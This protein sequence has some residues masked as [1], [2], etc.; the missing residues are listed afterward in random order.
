MNVPYDC[1]NNLIQGSAFYKNSD[2]KSLDIRNWPIIDKA[3]VLQNFD[4]FTY[5]INKKECIKCSTT[6]S[7]GLIL[8]TY[9]NP[10]DYYKSLLQMWRIR[11]KHGVI[12]YSKYCTCHSNAYLHDH[13]LKHKIIIDMK[14]YSLYHQFD[15]LM[16]KY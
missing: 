2:Y 4:K 11:K 1:L 13:L 15:S 14:K 6:G 9:W 5:K 8:D 3:D 10:G 16:L 7:S 12:P